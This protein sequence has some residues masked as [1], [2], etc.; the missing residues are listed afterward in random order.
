MMSEHGGMSPVMICGYPKS[1][2]TLL[3]A[4]LDRHP[5]LLVFPEEGKFFKR[6]LRETGTPTV[7]EALSRT[8]ARGLRH[9]E[10]RPTSGYRDYSS[11]DFG[12]YEEAVQR[13]WAASDHSWRALFE[14][15][16]F[17]YGEITDQLAASYW[18]E[19][20]PRNE[21]HL[22]EAQQWW[23]DL[24][25]IYVLRDPRDNY[26]SYR[27]KRPNNR[28]WLPVPEFVRGWCKSLVDWNAFVQSGGKGLL[29]RYC[30][31]VESPRE[32]LERICG[33]LSIDWNDSLLQPTR[34]GVGWGG[35]STTGRTLDGISAAMV[36]R[37]RDELTKPI[38]CEIEKWLSGI[39]RLFGWELGCPA[40]LARLALATASPRPSI[41]RARLRALREV[42]RAFRELD[43]SRRGSG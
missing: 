37:Y 8:G 1:G 25:A 2:T 32:T 23:P 9:D 35:N 38:V 12:L 42:R 22:P 39:A 16:I 27:R 26:C 17:A 6:E 41:L 28:R 4:L 34:N 24:R 19:K 36:G 11:I 10:I 14:A 18:V 40:S 7:E 43:G 13:E 30:D 3:L 15:I 33:F 21:R 5:E 20:T 31:L 29:V